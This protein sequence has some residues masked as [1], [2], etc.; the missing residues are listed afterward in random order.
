[1]LQP[2]TRRKKS[3]DNGAEAPQPPDQA[4]Q[5]QVASILADLDRLDQGIPIAPYSLP[6]LSSLP[7]YSPSPPRSGTGPAPAPAERDFGAMMVE[8]EQSPELDATVRQHGDADEV[9]LPVSP[10]KR[11]LVARKPSL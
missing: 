11:G 6:Q 2:P 1:M 8:Q 3:K 9:Q 7:T 10:F 4:Q 5:E